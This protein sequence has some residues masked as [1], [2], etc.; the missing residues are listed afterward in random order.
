MVEVDLAI[1]YERMV[2]LQAEEWSEL[3]YLRTRLQPGQAF[4]DVGANLGLWTLV[5][6]S[7]V[8]SEGRVVSFEPNPRTF[9]KL[10]ANVARNGFAE[11]VVAR[12]EA[13]SEGAGAV[14]FRC[15]AEHNVSAIA[16]TGDRDTVSVPTIS[17]DAVLAGRVVHGMKLDTEGHELAALTGAAET[18][19]RCSPWLIVEF[20]TTLL[21]SPVLGEWVVY[22][23]L[24][25]LG[26]EAWCYDGPGAVWRVAAD[27]AVK[28]YRNVLFERP[29]IRR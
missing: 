25:A 16:E 12:A 22:R 26:Y 27:F 18:I 1:P 4:V 17:I 8:G 23:H 2:W 5:A 3:E 6:A 9:E 21:P 20:N 10:V 28:G 11:R 13:V 15:A 24:A 19:E 7:A 29:V 14:A